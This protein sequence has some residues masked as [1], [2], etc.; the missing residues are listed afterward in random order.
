M[1][2]KREETS[3][4]VNENHY[5]ADPS[6]MKSLHESMELIDYNIVDEKKMV[7]DLADILY[8]HGIKP[9]LK[10]YSYIIDAVR[11]IY[12]RGFNY[13]MVTKHIYLPLA[14]MYGE[15]PQLVEHCIRTAI[16]SGWS[17]KQQG[18]ADQRA[19]YSYTDVPSN[20]DFLM[21][22]IRVL[23]GKIKIID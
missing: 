10:G 23:S 18:K 13:L 9:N 6:A 8:L 22:L 1:L 19:F 21:Y 16:R 14:N 7:N 11:I 15:T 3:E 20:Y 17:K 12:R 2:T 5:E 4:F